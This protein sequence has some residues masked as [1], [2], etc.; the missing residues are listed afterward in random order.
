MKKLLIVGVVLGAMVVLT[1][2]ASAK[3]TVTFWT[4]FSGGEGSIMTD[5]VKKFNAEHPDIEVQEQIIE[6]GQ[7]Y[8]KLLT[9]LLANEAPDIG[10]MHLAVLPD[11]AS[12]DVLNPIQALIPSDFTAKFLPNILAQA[13]YDGNL[14]AVPID[15]HP[16][17]MYYNK[18]A[19]K[20]AGIPEDKV[21]PKTWDE[22]LANAKILKEKGKWGLTLETGPMLGE[23]LW[24]AM[25]S[26]LGAQFQDP[27]TGKLTLDVAKA[28][29][30]YEKIGEF[31][32]AG[33]AI[34]PADYGEC[35]SQFQSAGTGY[36]FNGVWAMS[37]YPTTEGLDF[38]VASL[39]AIAGSRPFT[40]GDSHSFIFPKKGDD[41]RLKAAVTFAQWFS[42]NTIEWAK[43][44]HLPVNGDV[45]KSEAFL[46]LPLRKDYVG[47]GAN[48]VLAPSTKGWTQMREEMWEIGQ[49][50]LISQELTPAQGAEA[51]KAKIDELAAE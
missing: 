1:L 2:T 48:A 38:G 43:A 8:N 16:M 29:Q 36:H 12:R 45:M 42:A 33:V 49:K 51:L 41:A 46:N 10:I 9:A 44:G 23:R 35:E 31:Y 24:L 50:V 13:N 15:T 40:W 28:A 32:K 5:L 17:V 47:V 18:K 3:T 34:S 39:P 11:Y 20:E 7:Y 6:W 19:L 4:L 37:V 22:L 30:A 25:Y 14:Y 27:A 26:Q 21:V